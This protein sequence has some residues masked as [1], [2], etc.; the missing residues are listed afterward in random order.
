MYRFN[1]GTMDI[2]L[3]WQDQ[4]THVFSTSSGGRPGL[5]LT[6]SR[7]EPPWG[8]SFDSYVTREFDAISSAMKDYTEIERSTVTLGDFEGVLSEYTWAA[9]TGPLHQLMALV[10]TGKKVVVFTFTMPQSMSPD[11]KAQMLAVLHTVTLDGTLS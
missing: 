5:S 10:P 1:E 3:E 4:T 7:D 11:Q 9:K 2:P 8:M 6:I